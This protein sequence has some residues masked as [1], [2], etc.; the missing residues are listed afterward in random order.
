MLFLQTLLGAG[1]AQRVGAP[2][3]CVVRQLRYALQVP[4]V[5]EHDGCALAIRAA[6]QMLAAVAARDNLKQRV[7]PRLLALNLAIHETFKQ[8]G[9][10]CMR[11]LPARRH[12]TPSPLLQME[13]DF[14]TASKKSERMME[15]TN[16]GENMCASDG[17]S[18]LAA[19]K[20]MGWGVIFLG[21]GGARAMQ[22][23]GV[24]DVTPMLGAIT[25]TCSLWC[26]CA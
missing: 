15:L 17:P 14:S 5:R 1:G 20:H 21:G 9:R 26:G 19:L 23:G 6:E 24:A 11:L 25:T 22:L 8:V 16:S 12:R 3:G 7:T 2:H 4:Q 10:P 13:A 18:M